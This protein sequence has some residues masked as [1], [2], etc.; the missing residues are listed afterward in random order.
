[1]LINLY[2]KY[3]KNFENSLKKLVWQKIAK[4]LCEQTKLKFTYVQV[5]TK[6]KGLLRTYKDIL[7]HNSTSGKNKKHWEY[8]H[9]LNNILY[10]KPEINAVA[11]CSSQ[12]GLVVNQTTQQKEEKDKENVP[13]CSIVEY[14]SS[15]SQKRKIKDDANERRHKEKMARLDKL[16]ATLDRMVNYLEK[17][18]EGEK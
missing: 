1:M 16:Q 4:E 7:K 13:T 15:F 12:L 9:L 8:F 10:K 18:N 5:D 3:E 6:W 17:K 14:K 11:T 2:E